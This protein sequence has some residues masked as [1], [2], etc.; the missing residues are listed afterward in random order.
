MY[1]LSPIVSLGHL[2]AVHGMNGIRLCSWHAAHR[3]TNMAL[4]RN[5]LR[6]PWGGRAIW[7][8]R[9]A[10]ASTLHWRAGETQL[11]YWRCLR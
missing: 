8:S 11:R 2:L 5:L 3:G 1:A 6:I 10:K 7:P 4:E 9:C